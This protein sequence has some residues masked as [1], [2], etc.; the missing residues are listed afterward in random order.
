MN[1]HLDFMRGQQ[2]VLIGE[3][4]APHSQLS[5]CKHA[6]HHTPENFSKNPKNPSAR[7]WSEQI[8]WQPVPTENG[9]NPVFTFFTFRCAEF[10]GFKFTTKNTK[11]NPLCPIFMTFVFFVV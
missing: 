6:P 1:S 7:F 3:F 2:G 5:T 8:V 11:E 9:Q 4:C 10:C